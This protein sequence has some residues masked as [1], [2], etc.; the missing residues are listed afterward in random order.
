MIANIVANYLLDKGLISEEQFFDLFDELKKVRAKL[1]LIAVHEGLM[2]EYQADTVNIMQSSMDMK[3][4]DLAIEKG[5]LTP[6]QVQE[7]L[8]KQGDPY[9]SLAQALENL[10][11]M[12]LND[13][14]NLMKRY[15]V[16]RE[17]SLSS[18]EALKSDDLDR[19]VPLYLPLGAEDYEPLALL[20]VKTVM[21]CV[22]NN[23]LPTRAYFTDEVYA[24]N[25]AMQFVDGD[26]C[27]TTAMVGD[28]IALL[29]TARLFGHE[30]F[31][32]VDMDALDSVA[33]LIN[34]INGMY[35]SSLSSRRIRMELY[36]PEYNDSISKVFGAKMLVL[37][38]IV[39][40]KAIDVVF[41]LGERLSFE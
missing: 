28:G 17:L 1:G 9:L 12:R 19:I 2:T 37:P 33:E 20:T 36:P 34:C 29:D 22:D 24:E 32:T 39:S 11:I 10:G 40:N 6:H 14:D 7:L 31:E 26:P 27:L 30:D 35:A 25:G 15:Q 5:F 18:I 21:R 4:G 23:I 13:L 3:F 41:C 16:E 38:I 8:K